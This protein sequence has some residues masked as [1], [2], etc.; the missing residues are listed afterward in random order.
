MIQF[1]VNAVGEGF[2][3]TLDFLLAEFG[4]LRFLHYLLILGGVF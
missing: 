3:A 4:L 2:D 1:A